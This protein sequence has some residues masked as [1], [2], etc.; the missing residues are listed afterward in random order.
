M[1][2]S[3]KSVYTTLYVITQELQDEISRLLLLIDEMR[4]RIEALEAAV[5]D[6]PELAG[7][8]NSI[9]DKVSSLLLVVVVVVV[10]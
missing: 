10:V 1:P 2:Y 7:A 5:E 8:V 9:M 3:I 4:K 6:N